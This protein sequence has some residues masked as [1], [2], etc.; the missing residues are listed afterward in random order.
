[1]KIPLQKLKGP[2]IGFEI[3]ELIVTL[4]WPGQK[5]SRCTINLELKR[6]VD[7]AQSSKDAANSADNFQVFLR[8]LRIE[9][10]QGSHGYRVKEELLARVNAAAHPVKVKDVLFKKCWSSEGPNPANVDAVSQLRG[11]GWSGVIGL[12][13]RVG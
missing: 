12:R 11:S 6:A 8:E 1:M 3:D 4:C 9:E 7:Q 10:L 2:A 5:Q 13:E